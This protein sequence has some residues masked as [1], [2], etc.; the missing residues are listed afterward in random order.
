MLRRLYFSI[1]QHMRDKR[2][3]V[4]RRYAVMRERRAASAATMALRAL[5][6]PCC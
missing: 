4:I 3:Y 2:A 5:L 1:C 6:M